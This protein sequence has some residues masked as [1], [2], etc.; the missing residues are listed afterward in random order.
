MF[1]G[2]HHINGMSRLV[3]DILNL[4]SPTLDHYIYQICDRET[5][6]FYVSYRSYL[7]HQRNCL[8]MSVASSWGVVAILKQPS[9]ATSN[10]QTKPSIIMW[11]GHIVI[12]HYPSVTILTKMLKTRSLNLTDLQDKFNSLRWWWWWWW[13]CLCSVCNHFI[14]NHN[15][16]W[17]AVFWQHIL[18]L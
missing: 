9:M 7:L 6:Y 1:V 13:W 14:Y 2:L 4:N 5:T 10:L 17:E 12:S 18:F 8:F 11:V 16:I 15:V 3:Y